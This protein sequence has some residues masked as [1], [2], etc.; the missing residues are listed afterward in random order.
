MKQYALFT[1]CTIKVALPHIEMVA[2]KVFPLLDIDIKELAFTCCPNA[3]FRSMDEYSWLVVAARNLALAEKEGLEILSLCPGCTQ[4]LKEAN[5]ILKNDVSLRAEINKR[6]GKIG[7]I[8]QGTTDVNHH[9][10]ILHR[11]IEILL[12]RITTPL[13]G[14][15]LA[16]HTGCHLLMPS[17]LMQFDSPERPTKLEELVKILGGTTIDYPEKILCCGFGLFGSQKG[18]AS[19]I[20]KDKVESAS[21]AGAEAFVVPCPSCFQQFDRNQLVAKR[22]LKFEYQLPVFYYLQLVGL[23]MGFNLDEVGYYHGRV[24][25]PELE[26]KIKSL[27]G[28]K[29]YSIVNQKHLLVLA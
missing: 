26:E 27:G 7:L 25:S 19:R 22:E 1:G 3:D 6:L 9:L 28:K 21:L 16:A 24:R 13:Y 11:Q 10:V 23:A 17:W 14:I 12:Q 15:K 20:I 4:T 5:I 2:R 29:Y 8:F 18:T